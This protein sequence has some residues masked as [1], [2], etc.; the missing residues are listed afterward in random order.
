MG[1]PQTVHNS[2]QASPRGATFNFDRVAHKL[3]VFAKARCLAIDIPNVV[4]IY[5]VLML[6]VFSAGR[7]NNQKGRT[8]ALPRFAAV[9]RKLLRHC[10]NFVGSPSSLYKPQ[11]FMTLLAVAVPVAI[12]HAYVVQSTQKAGDCQ[13]PAAR[14]LMIVIRRA[15]RRR[16][17]L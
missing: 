11:Y 1:Q 8:T 6:S 5:R 13:I 15:G 17:I 7:M 12:E 10:P 4:K 14:P 9:A 2:A 16:K 3:V